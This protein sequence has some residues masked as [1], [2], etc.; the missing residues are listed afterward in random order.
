MKEL[1]SQAAKNDNIST[2]YVVDEEEIFYGAIGLHTLIIA[3]DY[4][5]LE[6]LVTTS[7]PYVYADEEI[8]DCIE[9]LKD[10]SEDSIPVLDR[11]KKLLGIITSQDIVEVALKKECRG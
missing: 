1:V 3:R 7:Y 8:E 2:L 5:E 6:S 10:Y 11:N 4:V 9:Y